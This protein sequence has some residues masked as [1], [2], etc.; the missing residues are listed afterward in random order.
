MDP[1]QTAELA[2]AIA[3]L[4]GMVA[5]TMGAAAGVGDSAAA[6]A[7]TGDS[8]GSGATDDAGA[9]DAAG[10]QGATQG[11]PLPS[12]SKAARTMR[13]SARRLAETLDGLEPVEVPDDGSPISEWAD[14]A[15][16][17]GGEMLYRESGE[18]LEGEASGLRLAAGALVSTIDALAAA[19]AEVAARHPGDR[20][21]SALAAALA[22]E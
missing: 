8:A 1:R 21:A 6:G 10:A 13:G 20:Q 14:W 11:E 3:A 12:L 9:G 4:A 19:A 7:S 2:A 17:H 16:E 22:W 5:R 15:G 18:S